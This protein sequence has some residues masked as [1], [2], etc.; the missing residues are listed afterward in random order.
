MAAAGVGTLE[1]GKAVRL[2]SI[3]RPDGRTFIGALDVF[4]PRG[5]LPGL[6]DPVATARLFVDAGAD[7]LLVHEGLVDVCLP[8]FVGRAG[9][10]VKLTTA[11]HE[12]ADGTRRVQVTSVR[13]AVALG[14]SAVAVNCF[15][16]T[17]HDGELLMQL[18]RIA[19][20]CAAYGMPLVPLVNPHPRHQFDPERVAYVCRVGAELGGDLVKSDYPGT[21]EAFGLAV[22][23]CP[24]PVIIEESPLPPTPA[25]TLR[26]V[27]GVLRAG[28]A[29][30]MF[31]HRIWDSPAPAALARAVA[32]MVHDGWTLEQALRQADG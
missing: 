14:A 27:D 19:E 6:R 7:A 4:I 5:L 12:T 2:A 13:R 15:L 24:R 1:T 31:A 16:G 29:G 17:P 23:T 9:L 18:G 26:T 20:E 22:A 32:G 11:A 28:G 8:A 30:V 25:G 21:P 10:I 3:L